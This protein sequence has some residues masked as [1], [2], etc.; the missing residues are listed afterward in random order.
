[1]RNRISNLNPSTLNQLETDL[2]Q[3]C[4]SYI[5]RRQGSKVRLSLARHQRAI[6]NAL[7]YLEKGG[8][9]GSKTKVAL[10]LVCFEIRQA[11]CELD[12]LIGSTSAEDV[13]G[14]IFSQFCVGK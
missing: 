6:Q 12:E 1:M 4:R 7:N 9:E 11:V 14:E 10:D 13:L 3:Y 5:D 8:E 2:V